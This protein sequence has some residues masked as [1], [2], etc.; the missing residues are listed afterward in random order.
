VAE[1]IPRVVHKDGRHALIVA[2]EPFLV[3]GAQLN[4]SSAW[5]EMLPKV[6]PAIEAI[7][8]NT[9][10]APVYWE[11][12]EPRPGDFDFASVDMLV[13][14]A[15]EHRV[16]L[17][18]LW[19]GSWKN[20]S[21]H[22]APE[23][24][25]RDGQHYPRMTDADGHHL[26]ILSVH[27][28]A[29]FAADRDAFSAL[30]RHLRQTD[31]EQ[32]TVLMIQVENES[33]SYGTVRDHSPAAQKAFDGAVPAEFVAAM[34]KKSGTWRQV[35]GSDAD[36]TFSAYSAAHYI[37]RIAAAGKAEYPLPMYANAALRDPTDA[38]A[39]PGAN[40]PSGGPSFNMLDVWKAAA[41]SLDFITPNIYLRDQ[42][43]LKTLDLYA[44]PDNPLMVVE[45]SNNPDYAKRFF[46]LL[47]RGGFGFAPFGIDF[48]GYENYPLGAKETSAKSLAGFAAN[49]QL[50]T[51]MLREIAELNFAGKLKTAVEERSVPHEHLEFGKWQAEVTYGLPQFGPGNNPPGNP[52]LD[53]RA[54]VAQLGPDEFL[55]AGINARVDFSL[56]AAGASEQT[57]YLRVEEGRYENGAWHFQRLWNG[58]QID[59]G[60][61]FTQ[62]PCVLRVKLN[63]F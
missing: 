59:W 40:Y 19:F 2:G 15:R 34:G 31:G 49:Y 35:F 44:R 55:V 23:W 9:L 6:W 3:L 10:E 4:N 57:E 29:T 47:G 54:L 5:P 32:R 58:D 11:Q 27:S 1:D 20:G 33:G 46:S 60:L 7:H 22:Y 39:R 53:G 13:Q 62:T 61:N 26:G 51:P 56:S 21:M 30:M 50:M 52:D 16:R 17:I 37:G 38:N 18:L 36:E 25:R 8:A 48:T 12:L 45:T 42:A 28:E 43:Y 41:P 24:V 14:Q 63:T